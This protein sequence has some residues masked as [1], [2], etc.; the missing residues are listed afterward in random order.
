MGIAKRLNLVM[1]SAFALLL[2]CLMFT[3]LDTAW[4]LTYQEGDVWIG[5]DGEQMTP[6]EASQWVYE[7]DSTNLLLKKTVRQMKMAA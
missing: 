2:G 1:V 4:G 3:S 5:T 6:E 7:D